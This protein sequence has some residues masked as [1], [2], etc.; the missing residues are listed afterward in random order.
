[1]SNVAHKFAP[2]RPLPRRQRAGVEDR[3]RKRDGQPSAVDGKVTRW[4]ARYVD[5]ANREYTRHFDRKIDAQKWINS[6]TA[7]LERG[8]HVDPKTARTTVAEWCEAWIDGYKTR[9][10]STVRQAEVHLK[11]IKAEFGTMQL[12]SVK[13]SHVKAWTSRLKSDGRADSYVYALHSRL[14]QVMSDAV[15]DGIIARNPCSRRTSPG[16]GGQRAYVA[17]TEQIWQLHDEVPLGIRPA[18][19][20]GAFVGLRLAE[21]AALAPQDVD[22]MRGVVSP[23][24]QWPDVPLKS[25]TSRTPVPIPPELTLLLSAALKAGD[26]TRLVSNE[27]GRPAGPYTIELAMRTARA[28]IPGLPAGFRFHD[29]RH[30]FASL[31]IADG[32]DVKTV[33]ARLRHASAKTTLDVYGHLWPDKDEATRATVAAAIRT[34]SGSPAE[35]LRNPG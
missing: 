33:Q 2:S 22:F 35:S 10:P 4:R 24:V 17:T 6:V 11:L 20:L 7:A 18:V 31:L 15:H 25:E 34:W 26:G 8:E 27:L 16:T 1:M 32:L 30:Y 9:R 19:L 14:S 21:A 5:D 3:W 29:L 23:T 13:P 28:K 12:S